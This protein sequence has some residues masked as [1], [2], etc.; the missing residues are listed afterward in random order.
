MPEVTKLSASLNETTGAS[1]VKVFSAVPYKLEISARTPR[2][3]VP[4]IPPA[5][6][7]VVWEDHIVVVHVVLP[8]LAVGENTF[9][10]KF[11]PEIVTDNAP[12]VG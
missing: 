1:N 5:H 8:I 10:P 7:S 3:P 4:V 6:C 9:E 2:V 11:R 12:V